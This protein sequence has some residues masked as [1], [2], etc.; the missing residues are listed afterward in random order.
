MKKQNESQVV[1]HHDNQV[2]ET[3]AFICGQNAPGTS[4]P[5]EGFC[6]LNVHVPSNLKYSL[7]CKF[8]GYFAVCVFEHVAHMRVYEYRMYV[9]ATGQPLHPSSFF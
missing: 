2:I 5:A 3:P 8:W 4:L 7:F 9:E 6:P 1:D